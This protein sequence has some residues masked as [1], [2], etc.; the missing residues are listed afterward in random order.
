MPRNTTITAE[1]YCQILRDLRKAISRKRPG[2]TGSKVFLIHDNARPHSANLTS[3]LLR[4]FL[5]TIF[6]HPAYSPDLAP[7]DFWLFPLLKR[8]LAGFRF[9]TDE[10]LK[11][12]VSKFFREQKPE[13][14]ATGIWRLVSQ[15]DKCLNLNGNY[16]E[17]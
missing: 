13:F 4:Q 5:W 15:Y 6:D 2:L 16:I 9:T 1:T 3:A 7:S 10:E 8:A 11:E 14:Y 12:A 17:K